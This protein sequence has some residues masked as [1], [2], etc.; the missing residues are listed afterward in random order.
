MKQEQSFFQRIG[1]DKRYIVFNLFFAYFSLGVALIMLG[2][3]LPVLKS[4]YALNYQV[5]GMLLSV[6]SIGYAVAGLGA[7]FLP[8]YLGLKK[9]FI[10]LTS[11]TCIGMGM[12]LAS[13]NPVWLLLAMGLIGISKGAVTNYNN[14]IMTELAEGDAG[15]LNLMHAFFAIGACL[16]PLIV[17]VCGK[18]DASGWRL[19]VFLSAAAVGVG[20]IAMFRMK[21]QDTEPTQEHS[22]NKTKVSYG[23]FKEKIFWITM[24]ICFFYQGI[25]GTMMG[26][27]TSF[28]VDSHVMTDSFAQVVTS[29]L[30]IALLIGRIS[31]SRLAAKFK[32][33]QMILA[34][35]IGQFVFL[36]M[37]VT[38][39][40]FVGMMIATIGLG[41]SMSGMYGTSVSNAG[42]LFT[43]Y[44]VCMGFFVLMTSSGAVVAPAVVGAVANASNMRLGISCLLLAAVALVVM[45]LGN[46][47]MGYLRRRRAKQAGKQHA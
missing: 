3:V 21:M 4:D 37:L 46:M 28:F 41:L 19:A 12:L 47:R 32:P 45:A 6:Q 25:E 30:W 29:T 22:E 31:C 5:G 27:L 16:A 8:L 24:L 9:S 44:P 11:G 38:S 14:Q 39:H 33:S 35:A 15:P 2:S 20:L 7:G 18:I 13:G 40:S 34:M 17:L 43:R 36:T 42:D 10:L 23:F 26:W 1:K